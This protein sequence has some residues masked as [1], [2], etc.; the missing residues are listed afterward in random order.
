LRV[1]D[2]PAADRSQ[3]GRARSLSPLQVL[4]TLHDPSYVE[5]AQKLAQSAELLGEEVAQ[6]EFLFARTLSRQPTAVEITSLLDLARAT[7]E[8]TP[9]SGPLSIEQ[10]THLARAL[11]NSDEFLTRE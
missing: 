1:F 7:E 2:W 6:L 5:A 9:S 8:P 3:N 11:L 4:T 10:L